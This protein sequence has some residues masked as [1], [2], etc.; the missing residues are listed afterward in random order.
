M[1][2][3]DN[4]INV[5]FGATID[6]FKSKMGEVS[7]IFKN[8]VERFGALAAVVAGGAAFKSF[9]NTANE[10]NIS[11]EKMSRTLGISATEAGAIA[12]AVDDVGASLGIAGASAETYTGAFLKFN[13]QL[14]TNS[15][16]LRALGVDVDAVKNGT[17]TSNEVF[18]EAVQIVGKYAPGI[19]QTQVAMQLF[20]RSVQD[21][22]L[23]MGV[24]SEKIEEARKKAESLN[25]T[26]TTEGV[27]GARAYRN[28]MNDVHDV[29]DGMEKTVGEGV[30]PVFT[31]LA[32]MFADIG[33]VLVEGMKGAVETLVSVW[34]SLS[35]AVEAAWSVVTTVANAI[36]E[37]LGLVFGE[38]AVGAMQLFRDAL[39]VVQV[40][41]IGFRIGVEQI[42]NVVK[43]GLALMSSGF[44][45]F[46]SVAERALHL[47]FSGAKA[48][49]EASVRERNRILQDGVDKALAIAAK[50]RADMDAVNLDT[51]GTK[52]GTPA[53]GPAPGG[54]KAAEIGKP[55]TGDGGKTLAAKLAL[56][57]AALA[58]ELALDQE[59]LKEAQAI[60]DDSYK[61]NLLSIAEYFDAKLAI[62]KKSNELSIAEKRQELQRAADAEKAAQASTTSAA[63]PQDKAKYDTQA[64]KFKTEQV[65]L[66]GE[67]NVLEAQGNEIARKNAADR[68]DA[69]RQLADQL[70]TIASTRAKAAA[71]NEVEIE[72]QAL[73]Q[74]KAL[75]Q[76]DADQA[77]EA[78]RQLEAKSYAATLAA[79]DAK[80]A[81]I[82]GSEGEAQEAR[83]ALA[84]E[85]EAA[86]QQHQAKLTQIDNKAELERKKYSIQAQ[87]SVQSSFATMV[88]DLLSG[89]KKISDVFRNFGISVA[90]TFT[91]LIAQKFTDRLFD[92]TGANAAI[93]KIVSFFVEGISK[94]VTN[95]IAGKAAQSTASEAAAVTEATTTAI[96]NKASVLSYASVAAVAAMASVAAI[97]F[98][99]WAMA[100]EVGAAT[101]ANALAYMLSAKGG[102]DEVP[103]DQ[104][105]K[106]HEKETVLSAPLA[107]GIRSMVAQG[108]VTPLVNSVQQIVERLGPPDA[109]VRTAKPMESTITAQAPEARPVPA[110]SSTALVLA[111]PNP[112]Q[113]AQIAPVRAESVPASP[114]PAALPA[115]RATARALAGAD[116]P[117]QARL[118]AP[119]VPN[120]SVPTPTPQSDVG[121]MVVRWLG[122]D[123]NRPLSESRGAMGKLQSV[124]AGQ[125][126][127]GG[128]EP[129]WRVPSS[130]LSRIQA[131]SSGD[132]GSSSGS[133]AKAKTGGD[134]HVHLNLSSIDSRDAKRFLTENSRHIANQLT[135]LNRNNHGRR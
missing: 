70:A 72:R 107:A 113:T 26:I 99:G 115:E 61:N 62:E 102:L 43:T 59:H 108:G 118:S 129:W 36:G 47:D 100:P 74:K 21:V 12:M 23:L 2:A 40:V 83:E 119:E 109:Q 45:G 122:D 4:E 101:Y 106:V 60:Y 135:E 96:A 127:N 25:L 57:K 16:S 68:A 81:A 116:L 24:T 124:A 73:E 20:G 49:W 77:F 9:I 58:A 6:D 29:L 55:D 11:A 110:D 126:A 112:G 27:E 3:G 94:M 50:G 95:W 38:K 66:Q 84:A 19:D 48:E 125:P 114:I 92:V 90:N 123:Q 14:R 56:E 75:R 52:K 132:G 69:E 82:H 51:M 131:M 31:N 104:I 85:A 34:N 65:K 98:Y 71:D 22:Q 13:R 33:P 28:A 103:S 1:A 63:T 53:T 7:S 88:N 133:T 111:Q 46:A 42:V 44:V 10:V 80:R 39:G 89:T 35:G 64:L 86:E 121:K 76:I 5:K 79:L 41:F 87:Q 134:T 128:A 78:E 117:T 97:P 30:M 120:P 15:D 91:N 130:P 105:M 18:Q 93:D 37:T 54:K 17:K 32:K 8:V 67:I